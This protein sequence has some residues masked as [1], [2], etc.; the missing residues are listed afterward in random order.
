MKESYRLKSFLDAGLKISLGS[1]API[2]SFNPQECL[3][4]STQDPRSSE[5]ISLRQCFELMIT[6]GRQ[7]AGFNVKKLS[8]DSKAWLSND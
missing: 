8:H 1:D 4:A 6:K 2:A 7:N 3:H 5:R